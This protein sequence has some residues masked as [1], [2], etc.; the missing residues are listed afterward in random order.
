MLLHRSE[1]RRLT[2]RTQQQ[3]LTLVPLKIYFKRGK[4][5]VEL[6]LVRGKKQF[7]KRQTLPNARPDRDVDRALKGETSV[8]LPAANREVRRCSKCGGGGLYYDPIVE[9]GRYGTL[10]LC[11]CV[12]CRCGGRSPTNTGTTIRATSGVPAVPIAAK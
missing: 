6:A 11:E 1:I 12:E 10:R 3:G 5:K 8:S 2:G 9:V 7:D 4:A